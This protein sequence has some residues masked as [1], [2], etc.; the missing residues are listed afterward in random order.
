MFINLPCFLKKNNFSLGWITGWI[1]FSQTLTFAQSPISGLPFVRTFHTV[2]YQAGIQNWALTQDKRGILYVANNF[3][4]LEFDGVKWQR[5]RVKNGTKV[6]TVAIDARGRIYVGC[7]GDFG[8]FF[9]DES[10]QLTYVSLADSLEQRYRNF[11]EAWSIFIDKETV[12]FCTF[13]RIYIYNGLTFS[14]AEPKSPLDLSFLVNRDLFVT[15]RQSGISKLKGTELQLVKGGEYFKEAGVSSMTP[16]GNNYFLVSTFQDGIYTLDKGEVKPWNEKMQT[17]FR[18]AHVNCLIRLKNGNFAVGTQNNGLLILNA[19]GSLVMQLTRGRGLENRTVLGLYEDD[20]HNLW[21]GQ[22][23]GISHVELGSPFT[24]I[25]EQSGLPGTGYAAF[26]DNSTFYLGTNTGLYARGR[27]EIGDFKLIENTRGQVYHVGKYNEQVLVGHHTGVL[28][29][30]GKGT[31][32]SNEPGAWVFLIPKNYPDKLI[33][34]TYSGLQLFSWEN[35]TWKWKKKLH[36]FNESSR[37]MAEDDA[38]NLWVTHGYKGAF[39]LRLNLDLDSI[40]DVHYYG[41]DKGFPSNLLINVFK[42][43]NELLFTSEDGVFKY[44]PTS[45][46][47]T[48]DE[49]FTTLLQPSSQIWYIQEDAFGNIYFAGSEHMGVMRKNTIGEY[50]LEDNSFN[51]IRRYLNDDL[52]NITILQNNDVL[53]GAKDGFIHFDPDKKSPVNSNFKT[54]IRRVSITSHGDSAFFKGNFSKGGNIV[55]QQLEGDEAKIPYVNNSLYFTFAA[56]SYEGNSERAYQFYLEN[57]DRGWSEWSAQT[58][59]EYT[60]LKEG[61][62]TFHVRARNSNGQTSQEALF[63]FSVAPPWYRSLLAYG[64]YSIAIMTLLFFAF[65][66]VDRKYQREQKILEEKQQQELDEKEIEIEKIAQQSLE[67]IT[68]LQNEKLEADLRHMNNELGTATMHL[69]NKNEFITGIKNQ[70]K[71][72]IKRNAQEESRKELMQITKD[73]EN[74]ISADSDWEHFQFHFDRVHGD[75]TNRF[76]GA[77]PGL[78]PQEI[79]LSAYLRMNLSTKEIA[80]L[81]NISVRGVEISRYRLRKKLH[82]D[83]NQNLQDFILNF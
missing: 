9:P 75:F 53:F 36:G 13:S 61:N 35:G 68:R 81:L 63:R 15:V 54:L 60:N 52:I 5:Y 32:I 4:L 55:D 30:S 26:L 72:I 74:N 11:D 18:E 37:V 16:L 29:V 83:R 46:N 34:G 64:L 43:R 58:Q 65:N 24:F 14:I 22:N 42:V 28:T 10:G 21:V 67:E 3:G 7:Q 27:D 23:N 8:Y 59:K 19:D 25:S 69:L 79:K 62:Y 76:K 70:L 38:G 6:R 44:N 39:R 77:F 40:Q 57:Y 12:Y 66:V 56:P 17:L 2:E 1:I 20:L 33:E 51:K 31:S 49:M 48:K 82:L 80:Q 41:K 78:S 45:D 50:A 73:I 47:F 71:H